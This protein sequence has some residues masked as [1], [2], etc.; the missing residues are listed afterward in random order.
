MNLFTKIKINAFHLLE[1][2]T[3][4]ETKFQ[5][6]KKIDCLTLCKLADGKSIV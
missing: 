1:E 3:G 4:I 2:F 6:W 5:I